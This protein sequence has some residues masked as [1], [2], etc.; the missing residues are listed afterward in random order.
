MTDEWGTGWERVAGQIQS[1]DILSS[2]VA[3]GFNPPF[4]LP[5]PLLKRRP[6]AAWL[7][8]LRTLGVAESTG[9]GMKP[10]GLALD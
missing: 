9:R 5:G 3:R 2:V 4:V 8:E 10:V 7:T 6:S 1:I